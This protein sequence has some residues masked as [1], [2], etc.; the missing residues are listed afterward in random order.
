MNLFPKTR[1]SL[2]EPHTSAD[3][4]CGYPA[5]PIHSTSKAPLDPV[6]FFVEMLWRRLLPLS[7]TPL[8][9]I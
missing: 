8:G 3:D 1:G 9:R 2:S 7:P 4:V 6:S 5:T